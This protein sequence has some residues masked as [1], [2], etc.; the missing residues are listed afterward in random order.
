MVTFKLFDKIIGIKILSGCKYEFTQINKIISKKDG[1]AVGNINYKGKTILVYDISK[2]YF[3]KYL[4]KFD[5]LLF[6]FPKNKDPFA[7]KT[8][9]IFKDQKDA[10]LIVDF[11]ELP[12]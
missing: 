9:G 3:N 12:F 10:D 4:K 8:E 1:Y 7:I 2:K 11:S 6:I 5:G